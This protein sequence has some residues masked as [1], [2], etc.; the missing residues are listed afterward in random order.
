MDSFVAFKQFTTCCLHPEETVNIPN[1][2]AMVGTADWEMP[3]ECWIKSAF[4]N[5]PLSHVGWLLQSSTRIETLIFREL[6]EKACAILVDIRDE[7]L[8]AAVQPEQTSHAQNLH[9]TSQSD[10]TCFRCGDL[11]HLVRDCMQH[12]SVRNQR[13]KSAMCCYLCNKMGHLVKNCLGKWKQ[14]WD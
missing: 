2:L 3:P 9:K 10:V 14:W 1:R 13:E 6:L 5:G 4:V 12:T 7:H 8:A 11:N